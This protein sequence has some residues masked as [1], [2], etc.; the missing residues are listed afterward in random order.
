MEG[1]TPGEP[2]EWA[3]PGKVPKE[4]FCKRLNRSKD[5]RLRISDLRSP[6]C[7]PKLPSVGGKAGC[8][9]ASHP[10]PSPLRLRVLARKPF[11]V[12]RAKPQ[13]IGAPGARRAGW[14]KD[15]RSGILPFVASF[16]VSFVD[17][18]SFA[19]AN[20]GLARRAYDK[21]CDKVSKGET[22]HP[23]PLHL[24]P[25]RGATPEA[26]R[27]RAS[28]NPPPFPAQTNSRI[29]N[30]EHRM[31]KAAI[32]YCGLSFVILRFVILRFCGFP[33]RRPR[34]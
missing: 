32:G 2:R 12:S 29:S 24:P 14:I 9:L 22:Q 34:R 23:T 10:P 4:D 6:T 7:P 11:G 13:R 3:D 21:A 18:P 28:F 1:E 16:V 33:G 8:S 20:Y 5:S 17:Q 31:S 19:A 27:R 15:M 25:R 30:A 26:P